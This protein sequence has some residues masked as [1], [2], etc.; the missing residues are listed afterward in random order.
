MVAVNDIR[1]Q[2]E[3]KIRTTE[4]IDS[5]ISI[6]CE[7]AKNN[8]CAENIKALAMLVAARALL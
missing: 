1:G 4:K 6:M 5:V 8:T 3:R 2:E 7:E